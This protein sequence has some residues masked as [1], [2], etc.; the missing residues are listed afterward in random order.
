MCRFWLFGTLCFKARV[1][2][3]SL[4]PTRLRVLSLHGDSLFHAGLNFKMRRGPGVLR[5]KTI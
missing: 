3:V 1:H 2:G 4:F 5:A